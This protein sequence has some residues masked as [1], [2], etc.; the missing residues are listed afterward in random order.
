MPRKHVAVVVALMLGL[1]SG[2]RVVFAAE[3]GLRNE[4]PRPAAGHA[5]EVYGRELPIVRDLGIG[6]TMAARVAGKTLYSIG[7]GKLRVFDVRDPADPQ[8]LGSLDGLGNT[9]QIE[10]EDQVA[11]ITSRED[12]V[13][14][15]DVGN[16]REPRL[17]CHYDPIE[18]ATGIDVSG[19]V[20]FV[21]CRSHGVELV[22][23]SNPQEPQ[24]L[25]TARTGEAQSV[26]VSN[27]YAYV[28]VWG[29]SEL[30][31][32]DVRNPRKPEITARC[33]LDGYGDGVAVRGE[34]VYVATGH[35]SR[36]RKKSRPGVGE[37][38]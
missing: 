19:D 16:P 6:P 10:V 24:H 22:D 20:M 3:G 12:G 28:G 5:E 38:V 37:V 27:G 26:D 7:R 4:A 25:G 18:V 15:V 9:R 33:P 13:F 32:V 1:I 36:A 31:V 11:Y 29:S 8:P 35:H 30:V 14:I 21:A 34:H 2:S 23:V 17:L